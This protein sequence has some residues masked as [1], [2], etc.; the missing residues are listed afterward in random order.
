MNSASA[1]QEATQV[2]LIGMCL[3][4]LL[5]F[6]KLIGGVL[7]QSFALITDG[8]HSL[9]DAITDVFVLLVARA[10]R[11]DPDEEHPYGHGRFESLGTIAMGV[12]FFTTA[13]ILL[14]DSYQRLQDTAAIPVPAL[15]GIAIA[16]VSIA[17]KEWIY[18]YTMRVAQRLNSSLLKANAWHSRTD[19]ISS[20]A[21]AIG[22]I[23]AQQ[24]YTWMDTVAGIFVALII[25]KI[26]W[27][28]C[29]D[30]LR[31]LVD[32]AIP[33]QRL[34]QLNE[35]ILGVEGI[36]GI[37][38]LRSRFSGGKIILEVRLLVN[39]RITVSEG[40]QLGEAVSRELTGRFSDIGDVIAHIDP[41]THGNPPDHAS[42]HQTLPDHQQI[43]AHIRNAWAE[44]LDD[45]KIANI[46]LHYLENGIEVDL[47]L[48]RN[49]ISELMAAQLKQ[50]ID[51]FSYIAS[52]RV[53]SK[54]YETR[55]DQPLS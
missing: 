5:G 25:A 33:S 11:E 3:D 23:A 50:A 45:D 46:S 7:T 30:S 41:E 36:L 34:Q 20:I 38:N 29:T 22:I 2:T 1:Q 16:L 49:E 40:H 10:A 8:I 54:L 43:I 26:G 39:S 32:T 17:T 42:L 4:L 44:L 47:K 13:G 18:Q 52:L 28:L 9:T 35:C 6:A 21:V 14:Y 15:S 19:A 12:V 48:N 51:Q 53:Y 55:L 31:E 27:E 37:T 24:G